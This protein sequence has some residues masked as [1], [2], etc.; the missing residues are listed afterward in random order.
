MSIPVWSAAKKQDNRGVDLNDED[1]VI[2]LELR[3]TPQGLLK[4][5][6]FDMQDSTIAGKLIC[7]GLEFGIKKLLKNS[8]SVSTNLLLSIKRDRDRESI[9]HL[10]R[11]AVDMRDEYKKYLKRNK[12]KISEVDGF[13]IPHVAGL[14]VAGIERGNL[15]EKLEPHYREAF[16]RCLLSTIHAGETESA[17]SVRD[18]VFML[19]ASRIGHGLSITKDAELQDMI[20]ERG[21]CIELCP[22]S[23]QFTNGFSVSTKSGYPEDATTEKEYV[24]N[25]FRGKLLLTVNTDNPTVSHRTAN[26][27]TFAYPLSEEFIWLA[28]MIN[29]NAQ[30][31]LSRLEVLHLIYNGFSSMFSPDQ[32]KKYIIGMAD[33]ELLS[34]L[35]EEYLDIDMGA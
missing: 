22:K 17:R 15:P 9:G 21:I 10:I 8:V 31:P 23:N 1:N 14:D 19:S 11:I 6:G 26:H 32:A 3:T 2:H 7:V 18:A 34:L 5:H 30:I 16:E 29:T 13:M 35:A 12:G 24:Y 27:L 20:G 33:D 25:K 28:K 4:P